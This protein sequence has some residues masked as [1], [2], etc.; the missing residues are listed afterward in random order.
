MGRVAGKM[1]R[2]HGGGGKGKAGERLSVLWGSAGGVGVALVNR[3]VGARMSSARWRGVGVWVGR[4]KDSVCCG[5]G[6]V[7][8]Q[9]GKGEHGRG[10]FCRL[11]WDRAGGF[12]GQKTV[13]ALV[14]GRLL[15]L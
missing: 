1:E 15:H 9:S 10:C 6:E 8:G 4:W 11:L 2:F 12:G 14:G 7:R 5:G 13:A 3:M